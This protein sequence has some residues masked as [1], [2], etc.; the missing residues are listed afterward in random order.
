M[1]W[2]EARREAARRELAPVVEVAEVLAPGAAAA[3]HADEVGPGVAAVEVCRGI[4]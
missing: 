3:A 4:S 1:T 2:A